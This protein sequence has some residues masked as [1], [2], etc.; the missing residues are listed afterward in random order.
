MRSYLI[1]ID[2]GT[3]TIKV[4]AYDL[5]GNIKA[6]YSNRVELRHP[7]HGWAEQDMM[8][9]WA[10]TRDLLRKLSRKIGAENIISIGLSGQSGGLW[11]VDR[12]MRPVRM[13]ITWM[14]LRGAKIIEKMGE[15]AAKYY[16]VCGWK[17]FPGA[18]AILL[19]W[20]KDHE[21]DNF[22]KI[23]YILRCKDW[24]K[25]KLTGEPSSDLTDMI[26][27][28]NPEKKEYAPEIME[29][30]GLD[31]SLIELMPPLID[32]W[33]VCGYV[34][35]EGSKETG[36]KQGTP[37][38]SGAYD[39][40]SSAL[41]AG[42]IRHSQF[43]VI[44]GTA[45]IYAAIS[46]RL[47]KDKNRRISINPHCV[48]GV[49]V[50]NSQSMLATPNLDWFIRE[51]CK[52]LV[53]EAQR[54]GKNI[55]SVCDELVERAEENSGPVIFHPFLQGEIGPFTNPNARAMLFGLSIEHRRDNLIKAI[56]EGVGYSMLD[57]LFQLSNLLRAE[58][59]EITVI[60]GGAKS[61]TWLKIISNISGSRVIVP[62]GEEFG[63]RGA[64]M[65]AGV[66][67][68]VF[69]D[70]EDALKHFFKIKLKIEPDYEKT[71]RYRRIFRIYQEIYQRVWDLWNDLQ[72]LRSEGCK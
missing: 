72:T 13:G 4:A 42:A 33:K 54:T 58:F 20:I 14:D 67:V 41:G 63:C 68:G 21:P 17:V 24:I 50:L 40:C 39:V 52:D 65:N 43:F 51:F 32:S 64:A 36:L 12:Y 15:N 18:G 55:Y 2:S 61:R 23:K 62:V 53:E 59:K 46:D 29:L 66:G 47:L 48:P 25:L 11:L 57:N 49:Y 44:L 34:S 22:K 30:V 56:Y 28:T 3:T 16:D 26:G 5:D 60:G 8:E 10:K 69:K 37:V 6:V 27:F 19:R 70:H 38:V 7:E 1:G 35:E 45:G 9:I 71:K 31:R